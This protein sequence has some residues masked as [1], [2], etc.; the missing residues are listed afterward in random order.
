MIER[1]S[2]ANWK[3]SGIAAVTEKDIDR[4]LQPL[5]ELALKWERTA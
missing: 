2:Q 1:G 5:G 4:F 3:H